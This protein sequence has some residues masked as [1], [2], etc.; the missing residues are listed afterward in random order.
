MILSVGTL[1][2]TALTA[3]YLLSL[4]C[5]NGP[6]LSDTYAEKSILGSYWGI[7][8]LHPDIVK[9]YLQSNSKMPEETP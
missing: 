5:C 2:L 8:E 6:Y 7:R 4:Y 9:E 1:T 3:A